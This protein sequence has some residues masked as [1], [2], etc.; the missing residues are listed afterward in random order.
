VNA[1][2]KKVVGLARGK[3][4][5]S[6]ATLRLHLFSNPKTFRGM[7]L[8]RLAKDRG[9]LLLQAVDK[10]EAR[11]LAR[12]R[13][14]SIL[15]PTIYQ[16]TDQVSD[17]DESKW[18]AEFVIKPSHGS[19]AVLLVTKKQLPGISY[20]AEFEKFQWTRGTWGILSPN[21][22]IGKLKV[23]A[24]QW[25]DSDFSYYQPKN[26]EWA[27]GRI[28][29]R[30]IVEEVLRMDETTHPVELRFH[31]F[32]GRVLVVRVTQTWSVEKYNWTLDRAGVQLNA[33]LSYDRDQFVPHLTLPE[34]FA[35]AVVEAERL[36]RGWDY[37][38]V[39]LF[40]TDKGIYFSEY[41]PYPNAGNVDFTPLSLSKLLAGAWNKGLLAAAEEGIK[42]L[43]LA[44]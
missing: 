19:G 24:K 10:V 4:P 44:P 1:I 37:I 26:P 3:W 5:R 34:D 35:S 28:K 16:V 12:S 29:R 36:A 2:R 33:G 11:S 6:I 20:D 8:R 40:A 17:L 18:P 13:S 22:D 38:R 30:V 15:L 7:V 31:C 25:L 42:Q 39:D 27:Y 41:T 43:R 14:S 32:H 23:L 21:F 9:S